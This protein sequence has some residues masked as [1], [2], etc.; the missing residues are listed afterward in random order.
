MLALEFMLVIL[1]GPKRCG[2]TT[3]ANYLVNNHNFAYFKDMPV[4]N[5]LELSK[6]QHDTRDINACSIF[7]QAK[8]LL[9][10]SN[11]GI[12]IVVDRFHISEVVYGRIYR[13]YESTAIRVAENVFNALPEKSKCYVV[14][15]RRPYE[16][17]VCDID[18]KKS[19]E[20]ERQLM[21]KSFTEF[22]EVMLM[23][24][25]SRISMWDIGRDPK[26]TARDLER[27]LGL[28]QTGKSF[29]VKGKYA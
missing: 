2:K 5:A 14:Y 10:M 18:G 16:E 25:M 6:V 19:T 12:N 9:A 11:Q 3:V 1:E 23:S 28:Q 24:E 8:L 20:L 26:T 21:L 4:S 13:G 29:D 27:F 7:A 15:I 22:D 17:A